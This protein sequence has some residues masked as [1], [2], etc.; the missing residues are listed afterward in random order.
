MK[1]YSDDRTGKK[2]LNQ[3]RIT[4]NV[5]GDEKFRV[6]ARFEKPTRYNVPYPYDNEFGEAHIQFED[7]SEIE[8]M[9]GALQKLQEVAAT[10]IGKFVISDEKLQKYLKSEEK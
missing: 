1:V 3:M 6:I 8:M 5:P 2:T 9:I 7:L 10:N 4:I